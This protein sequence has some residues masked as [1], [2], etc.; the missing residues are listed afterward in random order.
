M[1]S[2]EQ[3]LLEKYLALLCTMNRNEYQLKPTLHNEP[4]SQGFTVQSPGKDGPALP[5]SFPT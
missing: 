3:D 4:K 5:G 2:E 1:T